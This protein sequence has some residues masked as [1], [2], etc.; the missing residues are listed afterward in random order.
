[1]GLS[2]TI[3]SFIFRN[4]NFFFLYFWL[5]WVFVAVCGFSLAA[6]LRLLIAVASRCWPQALRHM[7]FGS[8][9]AQASLLCCM[10]NLPGPE[11]ESVSPA[12]AGKFLT[13]GP[14]GKSSFFFLKI[15]LSNLNNQ[16]FKGLFLL[17]SSL[18]IPG[19]SQSGNG[20]IDSN[21]THSWID[22]FFCPS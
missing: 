14:P 20:N 15:Q 10:W 22:P 11:T 8:C 6:V 1:M 17:W 4:L 9:G 3:V 7:G 5:C 21:T 12:L 19:V 16:F 2:A 18:L 13:I